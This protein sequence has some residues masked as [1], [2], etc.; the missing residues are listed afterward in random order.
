MLEFA[1]VNVFRP[2][3]L[4]MGIF[5]DS[6]SLIVLM[7]KKLNKLGPRDMYRYLFLVDLITLVKFVH[8]NIG[9]TFISSLFLCKASVFIDMTLITISPWI[10]GKF[11]HF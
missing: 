4:F 9:I 6:I 3:I 1:L 5:G 7:R 8:P 11:F 2:L 10:I